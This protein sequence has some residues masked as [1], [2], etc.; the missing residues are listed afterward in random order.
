MSNHDPRSC[1][2]CGS[3]NAVTDSRVDEIRFRC[4]R[5]GLFGL[6][7]RFL[8]GLKT[9][10]QQSDFVEL[11]PY[12]SAALRQA[13][14]RGEVIELNHD[15]WKMVAEGHSR[16][17]VS[18][19]LDLL[20]RLFGARSLSPGK[21]VAL[22]PDDFVLVDAADSGEIKYL[23]EALCD[24]SALQGDGAGGSNYFLTPKGWERLSPADSGGVP[25]TC[26]V[27]MAFDKSLDDV[28]E[29][30]I[31]PAVQASGLTLVRVDKLEHNGIVTDLIH[32][33]IRRAQVVVADVTLQ[34]QG[35]YFE[36]GLALGL[37]RTVIW[38]CREDEIKQV[39]FDTRQYSHVVWKDCPDFRVKLETRIRAT[40]SIPVSH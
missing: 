26:F 21:S 14:D 29:T 11:L 5:C 36:A 17:P 30:A 19:K 40:V 38:T 20:L 10:R 32:A 8:A 33:E 16:T 23:A 6:G 4:D 9:I 18:R 3:A 25:G 12:L 13:S 35:V 22:G 15:N 31:K 24:Q 2:V 7:F 28:F 37:G 39:H 27:A 1:P 34:R